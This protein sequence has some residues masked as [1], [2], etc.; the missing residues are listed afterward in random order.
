MQLG[1]TGTPYCSRTERYY[2]TEDY[3]S[4]ATVG[5]ENAKEKVIFRNEKQKQ[6]AHT[7]VGLENNTVGLENTID[8]TG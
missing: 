3:Y 8:W 6:E 1:P 4:L 7:I 5:L 2:W